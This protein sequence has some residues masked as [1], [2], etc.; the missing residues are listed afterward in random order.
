MNI[1]VILLSLSLLVSCSSK[2]DKNDP[3]SITSIQLIDR[4]GFSETISSK[5]RLSQ[6]QNIDFLTA[7]SYQKV[8]R[9]FP[10]NQEGKSVSKV[11]AYHTNGQVKQYLE[12]VEGRA[13]GLYREWYPNGKLKLEVTVIEGVGDISEQAQESWLF[14]GKSLV[15]HEDG[16]PAAEFFYEKGLLSGTANYFHANGKL[17]KT[18]PYTQNEVNG[19]MQVFSP[20]GL[21]LE[22]RI[23]EKGVRNGL[24]HG[25]WDRETNWYEE[26]YDEGSLMKA[27]YFNPKGEKIAH[28]EDGTGFRAIFENNTLYSLTEYRNGLP[29]GIVKFFSK[30]G[31]LVSSYFVK[32]GMKNGEEIHYYPSSGQPKLSLLWNDDILQGTVKTWYPNGAPESQREMQSNK[33]KGMAFAWYKQG[34]LMLMEEYDEDLLIQGSYFKKG[35]KEP[36]TKIENSDGTA[37]LFDPDGNFIKK[38]PYEK[39]R[40]S[41]D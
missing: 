2:M 4:N 10:R 16:S 30:D 25:R 15:W 36:I 35:E 6:Y 38:I 11:T 12:I 8:L 31:N 26:T 23:Y 32:E 37:T 39:G 27:I 29:E 18:V 3:T 34:D 17:S 41:R 9:V 21:L 19:A 28:I 40:P 1:L 14:D 7:Q 13:N 33:K 24:S 20:E 22:E 5:E